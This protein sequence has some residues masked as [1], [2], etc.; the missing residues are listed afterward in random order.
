MGSIL[1]SSNS[2]NPGLSRRLLT[3]LRAGLLIAVTAGGLTLV[4]GEMAL[5]MLFP[6]AVMF[7]RWEVSP[8]YG[9]ILPADAVMVHAKPG[10]WEFRYTINADRCRGPLPNLRDAA[11]KQRIVVLGDSYAMG[12][13]VDDGDEFPAV[14]S[15]E[16]GAGYEVIN[17]ANPGWGLPQQIRR[18]YEYGKRHSPGAVVLQFCANDPADGAADPVTEFKDGA[19]LFQPSVRR[20]NPIFRALSGVGFVQS[21]QIYALLRTWY[22]TRRDAGPSDSD[23]AT[24]Q[25][26]AQYCAL[27]EPFARDLHSEG[28]R[29][30]LISVNGQLDEFPAIRSL[31][32]RL[33]AASHLRYV[34]VAEWFDGGTA[35]PSPEGHQWGTEAH[36]VIG[37][38][39]ADILR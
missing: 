22:E 15:Q 33:D 39:L 21:S 14:M 3:G 17:A 36:K 10:E 24:P 20:H 34:E 27:L 18:Y 35:V 25:V 5:R 1:G 13:G 28:I 30:V 31:V 26:E 9:V 6:Q 12:M 37:T 2:G 29:L 38:R 11:N 4:C 7:P 19:F 23:P 16:L 32:G 8:D